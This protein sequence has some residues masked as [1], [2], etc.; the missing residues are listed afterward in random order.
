M[1]KLRILSAV[2]AL[3]VGLG[4]ATPAKA[5]DQLDVSVGLKTFPLLTNKITGQATMAIVFDPANAASKSDADA[6]KAVL[7]A[8][9]EAPGGAKL[10]AQLVPVADIAK[11]SGAKVI[12]LAAGTGKG[13]YDAVANSAA[14]SGALSISTDLDCAKAGK[15]VLGIV[16]KPNV[17]IF[18]SKAAADAAHVGFAAAFTMLAKPI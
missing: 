12:L 11:A 7:D 17:E 13:A 18:Y 16:S 1:Y 3:S 10:V 4:Q 14:A 2:A 5:T 6:V 15:C 8:G 9:I